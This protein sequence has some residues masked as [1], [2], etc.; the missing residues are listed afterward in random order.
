MAAP[1]KKSP[2]AQRMT[3]GTPAAPLDYSFMG[4]SSLSGM[5]VSFVWAET[6]N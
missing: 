6:K 1:G 3:S 5:A 2:T 4:L